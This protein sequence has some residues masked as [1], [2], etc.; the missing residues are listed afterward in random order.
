MLLKLEA[1]LRQLPS[2]AAFEYFTANETRFVT[3]SQQTFVFSIDQ[4]AK[5][6]VT[7]VSAITTVDRAAP[8]ICWIEAQ[9]MKLS[10]EHGLDSVQEFKADSFELPAGIK[11]TGY[12]LQYLVWVPL[13]D[14]KKNVI[15]GLLQA[16][17][18]PWTEADLTV[19]QH[20]AGAC[21][22]A[23]IALNAQVTGWR[24]PKWLSRKLIAATIAILLLLGFVPVSM[25]ALAPVEVTPQKPFIVTAPLEGVIER[26]LVEPNAAVKKGQPLIRMADTVLKNRLEVAER[27]VRVAKAKVKK[28]SQLAFVDVRG[29]HQLG[30]V[31]AELALRTAEHRYARDLLE[32]SLIK[33]ERD[34]IAFYTDPQDLVGRPAAVGER[35]MELADPKRLQF[36]IDLPVAD[37]IVLSDGARVKVFLD[38]DPLNPIEA[39]LVR[40][41]FQARIR[42]N[43]QL[44]FRLIAKIDP[45]EKRPLRLGVRGTAQVYSDK[46]PL[47]FYLFRRP[48]SALRQWLGI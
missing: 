14:L 13:L 2:L 29:R 18:T 22:Y 32:R 3:R 23:F 17:I 20:V 48:V 40:A 26:V 39:R 19:S 21:S 25:S 12:P 5:P 10:T 6:R 11:D 35:L 33:A 7:A 37:S 44:A 28:A 31:R 27:E 47:A 16:R 43:K 30:V 4:R 1:D 46:V 34:G 45:N 8:L 42:D 38:S 9:V 15:G 36:R 41:D 24:R